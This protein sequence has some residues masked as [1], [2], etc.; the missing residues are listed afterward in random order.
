M[1]NEQQAIVILGATGDLAGRKLIPAL[2][3]LF[4]RGKLC[5]DLL[6]IGS[7]RK[8]ITL[9]D[10][11]K[12][13]SISSEF[14]ERLFYHI[15]IQGLRRFI[16]EQTEGDMRRIIIFLALPPQTYTDVI[17]ELETEGFGDESLLIVEK[18]FGRNLETAREL[19]N[20]LTR[21]FKETQI[22]RSD[23]YLAKEAVQNL[24]IFRFA[25]SLFEPAWNNRY[26]ESI[27]INAFEEIGV[28][29]RG[30]YYDAAGCIRDMVQNHLFQLLCLTTMEP[31]VS[32]EAEEIRNQK[33]NVLKCVNIEDVRR[34]Q[35][36]GYRNEKGVDPHSDTETYVEMKLRI[37]NYRWVGV[38][39]YLRAGKA[40]H[41]RGTEIGI[42]FRPLPRIL[43]NREGRLVPNRIIIKVQ[44]AEG[45]VLDLASK[46][47]GM[48]NTISMSKM[49]F[50][51]RQSFNGEIPEAYQK[52]LM[53]ALQGDR[54]L[55]IS[56]RETELSWRILDPVL[57]KGR[58]FNYKQG[59][60]P[61]TR[62][63]DVWFDFG[64][65]TSVC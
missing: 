10:F 25:N 63:P 48:D 14:S 20:R 32:I 65:Y 55:F 57:D 40:T 64:E 59:T 41:R 23:H 35:Y 62:Y 4:S 58:L 22:F 26:I 50:C 45:I 19:N 11:R 37:D 46:V 53:D 21:R 34:G 42:R 24:L 13:F 27:Q 31:P 6:V 49:S 39:V 44:P 1:K 17:E 15:G 3:A 12:R 56:D 43:F 28:G 8:D 38:P 54:T 30:V 29:S 9:E 5:S 2:D 33:L 52:L 61:E 60:C 47:P 51:Y 16:Q 36:R 7:G 18:P